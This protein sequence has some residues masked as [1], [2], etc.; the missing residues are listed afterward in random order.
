MTTKPITYKG[1]IFSNQ[2]EASRYI[3]M[4][5]KALYQ[6]GW[7]FEGRNWCKVETRMPGKRLHIEIPNCVEAYDFEIR[8]KKMR[9]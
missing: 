3:R 4:A 9:A 8:M 1:L 2:S 7:K 6:A 5:K